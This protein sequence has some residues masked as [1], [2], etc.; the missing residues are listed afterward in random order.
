MNA[1]ITLKDGQKLFGSG[2]V[3]HLCTKE[4][5]I[6]IPA[7]S[8]TAPTIS[9]AGAVVTIANGNEV[10]GFFMT[11]TSNAVFGMNVN[12]AYIHNNVIT[13][14]LGGITIQGY[15]N[16]WIRNN[17]IIGTGNP[18]MTNGILI[19]PATGQFSN[20]NVSHNQISNVGLA[21]TIQPTFG[22]ASNNNVKIS[23]NWING[24]GFSGIAIANG[25]LNAQITNNIINDTFSS[26]GATAGAGAIGIALSNPGNAGNYFIDNNIITTTTTTPSTRSISATTSSTMTQVARVSVKNNTI[27]TGLGSGDS[28]IL[29]AVSGSP[30]A[31]CTTIA[32]NTVTL[33]GTMMTNGINL[34]ANTPGAIN[35]DNFSNNI[36]SNDITTGNVNILPL[37]SCGQ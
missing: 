3:Q 11:T 19:D 24:F 30:A 37:R 9:N 7:H 10:A 33:L 18:T 31:F 21:I 25:V 2:M 4:G 6:S 1:G 23:N 32:N 17:L 26:G 22:A 35:I 15:K 28:G 36:S 29:M 14:S 16:L 20:I 34:S 5:R 13:T 8:K 27:T 12:G